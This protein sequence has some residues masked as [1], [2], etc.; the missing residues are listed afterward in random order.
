MDEDAASA[1]AATDDEVIAIALVVR[2]ASDPIDGTIALRG[3]DPVRFTGWMQLTRLL[4]SAV[5]PPR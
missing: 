5:D 4:S 1:A 2:R 3:G